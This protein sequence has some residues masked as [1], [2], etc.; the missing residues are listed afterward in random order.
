M[1]EAKTPTLFELTDDFRRLIDMGYP[2]ID[3]T[4]DSDEEIADKKSEIEVFEDTLNMIL[5]SIGDKADSYCYAMAMMHGRSD[6]LKREID[7][8]S[9]MKN[10]LENAE[11]RMKDRLQQTLEA[12]EESGIEKP[13]IKTDFR[14]IKLA[15]NGGKQPMKVDEEKVPDSYKQVILKTDNDKIRKALESGEKLDFAE[16]LPRGRH[17]TGIK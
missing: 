15:G 5:E 8:L 9:A 1:I 11:K 12:M 7:R 3:Y 4:K 2:E 6:I 14:T 13:Q 17:L 16:L 10:T